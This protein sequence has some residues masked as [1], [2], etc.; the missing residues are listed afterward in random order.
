[1]ILGSQAKKVVSFI[2]VAVH[3]KLW[4]LQRFKLLDALDESQRRLLEQTTRM[5]EV[6]R[7]R[8]IYKPGDPSAH[9][10]LVK[11]GVIRI[12]APGP[13]GREVL[14]AFRHPGD[15][16]GE[17]ALLDDSPRD[18]LADAHEDSLIC[19]LD[20]EVVLRLARECPEVG[21][22]VLTMMARRVRQFRAR[23]E[24]LS[25]KSASARVA[26][27]LLDL[28]DEHGVQDD[29]GIV[30]AFRL[31][32]RDLASLVGLT[33]ETVNVILQEFQRQGLAEAD[34]RAIRLLETDKLRAVR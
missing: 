22:R 31:S 23:I 21:L 28:A 12:A 20:R 24:Q 32:Q 9:M 3:S 15:I 27:A 17:L 1:V 16:F 5:Q 34:R 33:R 29:R 8:R 26:R 2:D 4:Y 7:G 11:A 19:A 14:L 18:H 6:E 30:I 13:D 25:Y 10:F